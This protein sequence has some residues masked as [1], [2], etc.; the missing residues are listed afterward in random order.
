[1]RRS[2][3]R[4]YIFGAEELIVEH[5]LNARCQEASAHQDASSV[6]KCAGT[7]VTACKFRLQHGRSRLKDPELP[8]R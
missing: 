2:L 1:M 3:G 5:L 8:I 7:S 6:E 4:V